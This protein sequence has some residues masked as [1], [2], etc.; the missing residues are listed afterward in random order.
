[1]Q[2]RSFKETGIPFL[3]TYASKKA[4]QLKRELL[5]MKR[6]PADA[7]NKLDAIS[8]ILLRRFRKYLL[9]KQIKSIDFVPIIVLRGGALLHQPLCRIF[10]N[11]PIG[12]I[13]PYR[14]KHREFP[15]IVYANI[16]QCPKTGIYVLCDV[17]VASGGS[18]CAS[19]KFL[20][21]HLANKPKQSTVLAPFI[22][23]EAIRRISE[24]F[25][26]VEIHSLWHKERI[27]PDGRMKGPGFDIGDYVFGGSVKQ[28]LLW[29]GNTAIK[30]I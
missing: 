9:S 15:N 14:S 8:C 29:A 4:D 19:L 30:R 6:S 27:S 7:C 10:E 21:E 23:G 2:E 26:N 28:R 11:K 5:I 1:M 22:T 18:I 25:D 13:L 3:H 17:L 20:N 24:N 16:P 12:V